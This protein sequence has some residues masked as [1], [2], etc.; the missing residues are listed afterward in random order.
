MIKIEIKIVPS[1][2]IGVYRIIERKNLWS[3]TLSEKITSIEVQSSAFE[4]VRLRQCHLQS[5]LLLQASKKYFLPH[6]LR[7]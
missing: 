4:D 6:R 2:Q 1:T 3:W 5:L 7:D